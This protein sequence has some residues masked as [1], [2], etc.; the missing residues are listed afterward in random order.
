MDL[1]DGQ[2]HV[3]V[4]STADCGPCPDCGEVTASVHSLYTRTAR[5]LPACGYPVHIQLTVRRFRC[6]NRACPRQTFAQRLP[7]M[8]PWHAHRTVR[9]TAMLQRLIFEL[10]AE[11]ARRVL[12]VLTIPISA[13]TLLRILRQTDVPV[14]ETPR[15]LGIDDWATRKGQRYGT[16]LV[17]LETQ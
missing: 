13:D 12:D 8:I 4:R 2:L 9:L 14:F 6:H 1:I 3:Q 16:I 17:D 10:S 5:E 7:D 11:S 15:I